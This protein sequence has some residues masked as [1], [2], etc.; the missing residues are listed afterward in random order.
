MRFAIL[1]CR[2]GS[3]RSRSLHLACAAI[4]GAPFALPAQTVLHQWNGVTQTNWDYFGW[5]RAGLGDVDGDGLPDVAIGAP[6][7][8]IGPMQAAGRLYVFSGADGRL[9]FTLDG[10]TAG[11]ELAW[12]VAAPGDVNRDG[13]ADILVFHFDSNRLGGYLLVSGQNGT[14]LNTF[15][16]YSSAAGVGDV[17]GDGWPDLFLGSC[18]GVNQG[19]PGSVDLLSGRTGAL[20]YRFNGSYPYQAFCACAAAGDVDGDGAPDLMVSA[21]GS[22]AGNTARDGFWVYSGRTGALLLRIPPQVASIGFPANG[23]GDLNGDGFDDVI[24]A[25]G[26]FSHSGIYDRVTAFGGPTGT[27]L[28]TVSAPPNYRYIGNAVS[29]VGDVDGDGFDDVLAA[30]NL[31]GT[32]LYS[33]KDQSLLAHIVWTPQNQTGFCT[34]V[35][36]TNGDD[37]PDYVVAVF[38]SAVPSV[39]AVRLFSGAPPGVST[40]GLGCPD[41][42]GVIPRVGCSYVPALG[43]PFAINLSRVRSAAGALLALGLS[44]T[45][46]SGL[47][48]PY[49]LT[50]LGMPGCLLHTAVDATAFTVT[51]GPATKGR[52]SLPMVIPN[53]TALRGCNLLAQWLVLEAPGAPMPGTTTRALRITIQ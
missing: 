15:P 2:H 29:H 39:T 21:V 42:R 31:T 20:I 38:A 8:N 48:L 35:G 52:A 16:G 3:A 6:A 13:H 19:A 24:S 51:A 49:D 10:T 12:S 4:F 25:G 50:P 34:G 46:W 22:S 53:D 37:F 18:V 28:F 33:G 45:A 30:G 17:D 43:Q 41:G 7:T 23:A 1:Q 14:I 32:A 27:L 11:E 47:P 9:I 5:S 44:S 26:S 36:D 40:L